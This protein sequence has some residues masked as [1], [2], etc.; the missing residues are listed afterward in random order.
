M[1]V[2]LQ[3][4]NSRSRK[5]P[6][7]WYLSPSNGMVMVTTYLIYNLLSLASCLCFQGLW[8]LNPALPISR[9]LVSVGAASQKSILRKILFWS[10]HS[11]GILM[12][13][14]TQD[15]PCGQVKVGDSLHLHVPCWPAMYQIGLLCTE[16]EDGGFKF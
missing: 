15:P 5:P 11:F 1:A 16:Q 8:R 14:C 3:E 2:R 10:C 13:F 7:M 12:S 9:D 6:V 4:D